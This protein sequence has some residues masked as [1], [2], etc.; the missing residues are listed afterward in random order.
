MIGCHQRSQGTFLFIDGP[1]CWIHGYEV[2]VRVRKGYVIR[3]SVIRE[4]ERQRKHLSCTN[5]R[6]GNGCGYFGLLASGSHP[7]HIQPFGLYA[8]VMN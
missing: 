4:S 1:D 6:K 2:C 7:R 8:L 3:H 5:A